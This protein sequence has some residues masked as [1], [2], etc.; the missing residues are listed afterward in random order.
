MHKTFCSTLYW[1]EYKRMHRNWCNI[2]IWIR[3]ID[4]SGISYRHW[5]RAIV[6]VVLNRIKFLPE[7]QQGKY[8]FFYRLLFYLFC[9]LAGRLESWDILWFM[10]LSTVTWVLPAI[11]DA[12][13]W[14][15]QPFDRIAQFPRVESFL[16]PIQGLANPRTPGSENMRVKS[17]VLL[18]TAGRRMQ[19][20]I[21]IFSE[22]GVRGLADLC[23]L[24]F[25]VLLINH[26]AC[27]L[28]RV[29]HWDALVGSMPYSLF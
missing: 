8:G 26:I 16:P 27:M 18:P 25:T 22:P 23:S 15:H 7:T 1:M 28:S 12:P 13:H 19:L 3:V 17:C 24:N 4:G 11:D 14:Y 9:R 21:L 5:P 2:Q 20:F 29:C 10:R 6:D